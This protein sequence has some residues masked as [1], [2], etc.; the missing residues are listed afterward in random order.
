MAL[1]TGGTSTTTVL[2]ALLVSGSM[3]AADLA[4]FAQSIKQQVNPVHNVEPGGFNTS[5]QLI[6]PGGRGI[7]N[8]KA[9]DYVMVDQTSGW[10][11]VVSAFAIAGGHFIHS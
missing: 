2:K 3:N 5:G 1:L 8:C 6:L 7:I 11:I 9:G 10:P 4:A